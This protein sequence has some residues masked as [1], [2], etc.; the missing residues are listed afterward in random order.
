VPRGS[1]HFGVFGVLDCPTMPMTELPSSRKPKTKGTF[2]AICVV[3]LNKSVRFLY[4][5]LLYET[6]LLCQLILLK[7]RGATTFPSTKHALAFPQQLSAYTI[8]PRGN[9]I[10]CS[11]MLSLRT[12]PVEWSSIPMIAPGDLWV[13]PAPRSVGFHGLHDGPAPGEGWVSMPW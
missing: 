4:I 3:K 7:Y 9:S 13:G 6:S 2:R 10:L 1:R 11:S 5:K 8:N 12:L